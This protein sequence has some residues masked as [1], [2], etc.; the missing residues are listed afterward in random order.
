[1]QNEPVRIR[2]PHALR[3]W[4]H[5]LEPLSGYLLLA[6]KLYEQ[7]GQYSDAWNFGP[8]DDDIKPVEWISDYIVKQWQD[9][10]AKWFVDNESPK[11]HEA[12]YLKLDCSKVKAILNWKPTWNLETGLSKTIEW[13]QAYQDK[14][15]MR[16]VTLRQITTY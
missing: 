13:Y 6:K 7:P 2:H 12:T 14:K 1:M 3:P 8:N 10:K 9:K 5:V 16:D 4:Q 11:K 15:N